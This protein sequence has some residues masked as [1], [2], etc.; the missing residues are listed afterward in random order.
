ME[1]LKKMMP[2]DME[3]CLDSPSSAFYAGDVVSGQIKLILIEK[4]LFKSKLSHNFNFSF[5]LCEQNEKKFT[6]NY[7]FRHRNRSGRK[8]FVGDYQHKYIALVDIGN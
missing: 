5:C 7:I 6:S 2:I 4:N 1:H 3:M 8:I